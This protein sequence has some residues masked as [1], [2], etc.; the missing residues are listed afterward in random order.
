MKSKLLRVLAIACTLIMATVS[1]ALAKPP[2]ITT[3]E[4]DFTDQV[5]D[6]GTF[7]LIEKVHTTERRTL[8]FDNT[9][10][11]VR[12]QVLFTYAGTLTNSVT[13]KSV[14]DAPDPQLYVRDYRTG[15]LTISG[16][17]LSVNVPGEG[18]IGLDTG[19]TV[20]DAN[21]NIIFQSGPHHVLLPGYGI[22]YAAI[23]AFL[24]S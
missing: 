16:L 21:W 20:F 22:T 7:G 2:E 19:K 17:I 10:T 14:V 11:P 8:F 4:S 9:G 3:S 23:C 12:V 6:C 1:P 5:Y 18:I 24:S 13:G 15:T